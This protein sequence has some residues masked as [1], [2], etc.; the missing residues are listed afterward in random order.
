MA[1]SLLP[2]PELGAASSAQLAAHLP[3]WPTGHPSARLLH[4]YVLG[5]SAGVL[6]I[7]GRPN[8]EAPVIQAAEPAVS[9]DDR[10]VSEALRG[11]QQ[12]R[13]LVLDDPDGALSTVLAVTAG[14]EVEVYCDSLADERRVQEA[15]ETVPGISVLAP[16]GAHLA[17]V[18][19]PRTAGPEAGGEHRVIISA[20]K[21]VA[22]LREY[23]GAVSAGAAEV[24]VVGRI[25]HLTPAVNAELARWFARVDVSPA[26]AKSRLIIGSQ[27]HRPAPAPTRF[28]ALARVP[29]PLPELPELTVAAHGA[30]FSGTRAD[31]G[32]SLLLSALSTHREE[33][34][35]SGDG[36][37]R[38]LDLGCGN[39]W[40]LASL[41]QLLPGARLAGT[42][43]S[44]AA[45]ASAAET[46]RRAGVEAQLWLSD[47]GDP[48]DH[49][50]AGA[51]SG[52]YDLI[53]LN[54][55]FHSGHSVETDTAARMIERAA[56]LVAPEGRLVC[57]FNSHLRY[58]PLVQ[59]AFGR[60]EQWAR[61]RR[62]TVVSA[63]A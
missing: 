56:T 36:S 53:V 20:P 3:G 43:V 2:D 23:L 28:P 55:P 38:V 52:S 62:F 60:S 24:I 54:P 59:R 13:T 48:V 15:A 47:A 44:K 11:F 10:P 58:R 63:Q 7:S 26:L 45:L 61:D 39:G 32:T 42:D 29:S 57:V 14:A 46:C 5:R 41:G 51:A 50:Q 18:P 8:T 30:C 17:G 34:A 16:A 19:A 21:T 1:A 27:P 37:P 31:P 33:L 40:L 35:A 4:E 25:K 49:P 12:L 22:G 9:G 6:D